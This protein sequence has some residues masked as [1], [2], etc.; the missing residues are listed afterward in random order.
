MDWITLVVVVL[1]ILA[2]V[3]V[4]IL[5]RRWPVRGKQRPSAEDLKAVQSVPLDTQDGGTVVIE[6]QNMGGTEQVGGGEYKNSTGRS[7]EEAA[8]QQEQLQ[9][10]A[11]VPEHRR[12]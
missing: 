5:L 11:P 3:G 6:Q 10:E 2:V 1:A 8:A 7:V 9:R 12:D 4:S